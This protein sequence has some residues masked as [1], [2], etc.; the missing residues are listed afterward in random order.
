MNSVCIRAKIVDPKSTHHQKLRFI[1]IDRG[2]VSKIT[3][4]APPLESSFLTRVNHP[5]LHLSPGWFDP[6]V[7]FGEPG[8]EY[9]QTLEN[10]LRAA[11]FG[12][13]TAVGV[14]PN[15]IPEANNRFQI[16]ETLN[17]KNASSN[18][19]A[20]PFGRLTRGSEGKEMA[21]LFELFEAGAIGFSDGK[22]SVTD[23]YLMR[24]ILDYSASFG[25]VVLHPPFDGRLSPKGLIHESPTSLNMGLKGISNLS[26]TLILERDLALT[27]YTKSKLH[28]FNISSK[29]ALESLKKWKSIADITAQTTVNHLTF[30]AEDLS[31]FDTQ[32]K[33]MPPLRTREDREAL[34]GALKNGLLDF[35]SSDH[36]AFNRDEKDIDFTQA[37]FGCNGLE[38]CF[39]AL[40][41]A[42]KNHLTTE[43]LVNILSIKPRNRF[44]LNVP[45]VQEGLKADFTLFSPDE[46]WIFSH[47]NIQAPYKMSPFIKKKLTGKVIGTV[48]GDALYLSKK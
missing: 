11:T 36:I 29:E 40:R 16:Q 5:D 10:G 30:T 8:F 13:F 23:P 21:E 42:T 43:D 25:G 26:E 20:Y 3:D 47:R 46:D 1:Y 35:V 37:A 39:G 28:S 38:S 24:I 41:S 48:V 27:H 45:S 34:I 22:Q 7:S 31:G 33:V 17:R 2:I 6:T 14:L 15:N 18:T 12:G 4:T 32:K 44:G 19:Q 9:R